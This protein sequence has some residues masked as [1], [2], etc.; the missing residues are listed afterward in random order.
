MSK[1][2]Q[3][4]A[5]T[6]IAAPLRLDLDQSLAQG[7]RLHA[8]GRV[9]EAFAC[10]QSAHRAAPDHADAMHL[11]GLAY[12]GLGHAPVGLTFLRRS[13]ERDPGAV[14]YRSNLATALIQHG[15]L[16]E[17]EVQLQAVCSLQPG[18]A[19]ALVRL[20]ALQEQRNRFTEAERNF[21]EAARLEPNNAALHERLARLRYLLW[22]MPEA[23]ESAQQALRALRSAGL[24]DEAPRLNMGYALAAARH[25]VPTPLS[26][27]NASAE[28][29]AAQLERACLERDLVVI[30][31]LLADPAAL[32]THALGLLGRRA[33]APQPER[34]NFPGL[35]TAAQACQPTMQRIADALGRSVKW[36][37]L[38]NGALRFSV[39]SD[40]ARADV[41]VDNPTLP[42]IFGGVLYLS[43]PEHCRGGTG[44]YR[45]RATGL[46]RRLDAQ[47]LR[48]LGHSSFVD[49]QKRHL[50]VNRNQAFAEWRQQRDATWEWRFEVPM[51]F[52]R[53][54]VFRS[55]FFHAITEVFGDNAENGRLV[56]LF[57][58]ETRV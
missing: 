47:E 49:F 16:E 11:L 1:A 20:A 53:L 18:Q 46:E 57:H 41:H 22:A 44:F 32:R 12:I 26:V 8:Q 50:P 52:N 21:S 5:A 2:A 54:V 17:A 37:S 39:D 15:R 6:R 10:Y 9:G 56:Q 33:G 55:D 27:L 14:L 7:R 51:R 48:A 13:I 30:D 42:H 29:S 31:D 58:F 3:R 19:D 4:A 40:M 24:G 25:A 23:M 34:G 36:D 35:Q 45:H 38:D 43:L 28:F